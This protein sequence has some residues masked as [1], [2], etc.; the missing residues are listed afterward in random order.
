MSDYIALTINRTAEASLAQSA[1]PG[2]PVV[3]DGFRERPARAVRPVRRSLAAT[4]RAAAS[5]E[6]RWA[7]RIDP[8]CA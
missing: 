1:L 4:L 6:R 7:D 2:A 5:A 3:D 8:A